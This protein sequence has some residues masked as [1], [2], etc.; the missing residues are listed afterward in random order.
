M[1]GRVKLPDD[2]SELRQ[3]L[4]IRWDK[5]GEYRP[6]YNV[7][8]T[9]LVPVVTSAKG[10]RTLEWMR[11]G[12]IPSWAK[13]AKIASRTF[14]ARADGVAVKPSFRGAWR[15]GRR[16]LIATGGFYEWRKSDK[17]PFCVAMGNKGPMMMAGL[18]EE[19]RPPEGERVRSSTII[20]T[21]ANPVLAAIHDR[22]PVI[23]G[24]EDWA[25]WLGEAPCADPAAL[26]KPFPA[27]RLALWPVA[28]RVG[29]VANEGPELAEPIGAA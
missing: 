5:L 13:D 8:P 17:Q 24:P 27:E 22:M 28:K 19:W 12:L 10:A 29:N 4:A 25:L 18:W 23:I 16:C 2:V 26:M 21:E 3:E 20:T 1:C 15:A 11:W 7:A 14:N 6:R 9:A